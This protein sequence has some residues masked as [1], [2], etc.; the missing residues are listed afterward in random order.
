MGVQGFYRAIAARRIYPPCLRRRRERRFLLYDGLAA[1]GIQYFVNPRNE[2]RCPERFGQKGASAS[3]IVRREGVARIARHEEHSRVGRPL[4]N[5]F[6]KL[7][8][9]DFRQ[10]HVGDEEI[11]R[12]TLLEIQSFLAAA[13][14]PN[15]ESGPRERRGHELSYGALIIDDKDRPWSHKKAIIVTS[16]AFVAQLQRY[17]RVKFPPQPTPP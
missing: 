10:D 5:P 3:K 7:R 9:G 14:R 4:P 2:R 13:G 17:N 12:V 15:G 8:P 1:R 16:R 6:G 11:H